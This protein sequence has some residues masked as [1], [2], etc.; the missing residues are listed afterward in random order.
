MPIFAIN[1]LRRFVV[2]TQIFHS[3]Q[4]MN[5]TGCADSLTYTLVAPQVDIETLYNYIISMTSGKG[6]SWF[7][8]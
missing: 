3:P 1:K 2:K 6:C 4:R 7:R 8:G 5:H